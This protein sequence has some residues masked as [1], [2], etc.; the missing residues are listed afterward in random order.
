MR[1][2]YVRKSLTNIAKIAR[3]TNL[4]R[5]KTYTKKKEAKKDPEMSANIEKVTRIF[6]VS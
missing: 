5:I 6:L 1:K 2:N 3:I 4:I